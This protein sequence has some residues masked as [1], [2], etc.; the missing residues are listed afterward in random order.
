VI[1]AH[2][3]ASARSRDLDGNGEVDSGDIAFL[4]LL[5]E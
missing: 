3:Q 2:E 5:F 1:H 4:L